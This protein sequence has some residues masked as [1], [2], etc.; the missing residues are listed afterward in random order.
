MI[1]TN[2]LFVE[3]KLCNMRCC[4]THALDESGYFS[5]KFLVYTIHG[6]EKIV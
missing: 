1:S 3:G 2:I 6:L 4:N 5:L